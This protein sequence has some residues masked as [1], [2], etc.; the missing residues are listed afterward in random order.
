MNVKS[1]NL[2]LLSTCLIFTACH[3]YDLVIGRSVYEPHRSPSLTGWG[4]NVPNDMK[5]GE[6]LTFRGIYVPDRH[7]QTGLIRRFDRVQG[8]SYVILAETMPAEEGA[9]V[10]VDGRII[11]VERPF[12]GLKRTSR[13]NRLQVE[14][15]EVLCDTGPMRQEARREY[16]RIRDRLQ[17]EIAL[18]GS[19]LRLLEDPQWRMDCLAGEEAAVAAA[20]SYD[21]MYAAEVQF[22][23]SLRDNRLQAVY[24]IEWFKG[25]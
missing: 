15:Y 23:F 6:R 19:K 4:R 3:H 14:E 17:E 1:I 24:F 5:E 13:S 16:A 8:W 10:A 9:L 25:E 21:L 7:S 22:L 18:P 2:A 12:T 11:T 20:H